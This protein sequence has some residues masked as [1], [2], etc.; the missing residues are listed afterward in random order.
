MVSPCAIRNKTVG[1]RICCR[2]Q[3]EHA[4]VEQERAELCRIGNRKG[5]LKPGVTANGE[6]QTKKKRP[7][8]SENWIKT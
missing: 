7:C 3:R 5:L 6:V 1:K 4:H 2:L 8:T